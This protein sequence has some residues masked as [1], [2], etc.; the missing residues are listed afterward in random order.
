MDMHAAVVI[1]FIIGI[2]F[3][4]VNILLALTDPFKVAKLRL[5]WGIIC[6]LSFSFGIF[7][8]F[9]HYGELF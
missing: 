5:T 9:V 1:M 4:F 8:T 6:V 2:A 3:A 7:M